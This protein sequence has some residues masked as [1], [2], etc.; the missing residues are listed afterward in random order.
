M[1]KRGRYDSP[2]TSLTYIAPGEN[3]VIFKYLIFF[4][5]R[6]SIIGSRGIP[7][8]ETAAS[9]DDAPDNISAHS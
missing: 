7:S 4:P 9:Q 5:V 8:S 6:D 3:E 2:P 1:S